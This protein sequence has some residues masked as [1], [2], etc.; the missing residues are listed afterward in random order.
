MGQAIG[1]AVQLQDLV[2]SEGE[3]RWTAVVDAVLAVALSAWVV[4][5]GALDPG[6]TLKVA[7]PLVLAAVVVGRVLVL[8]EHAQRWRE[9]RRQVDTSVTEDVVLPHAA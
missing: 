1:V 2:R 8:V 4:L 9:H 5:L 3:P 7:V 6:T